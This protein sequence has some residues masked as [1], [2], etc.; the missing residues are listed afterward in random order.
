MFLYAG[1]DSLPAVVLSKELKAC[2][3]H[4]RV[5]IYILSV[6]AFTDPQTVCACVCLCV[7]IKQSYSGIRLLSIISLFSFCEPE[8]RNEHPEFI[9]H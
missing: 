5:I 4:V 8:R 7:V 2:K 6:A 9:G 1:L 3:N